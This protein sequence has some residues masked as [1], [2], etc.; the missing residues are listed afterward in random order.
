MPEP[1]IKDLVS[2]SGLAFTGTVESRGMAGTTGLPVDDRTA[3]VQVEQILHAPDQLSVPPGSKIIV[4]L[5]PDQPPLEPGERA[6]FFANGLAY[7][8]QLTVA[9]VGRLPAE[10][11]AA[12]TESLAGVV[13]PVSAVQAV[14]AEIAQDEVSD[15]AAQA[16]AVVRGHVSALTEL[17]HGGPPGEHDPQWWKATLQ[18]DLVARGDIGRQPDGGTVPVDAL[19]ANSLDVQWRDWLKPKA[20]Q[21]G[22]WLLHRPPAERAELASFELK[23]SIDLQPSLQLDLLRERGL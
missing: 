17:P 5:S 23:H 20:G 4:Q 16:D 21:G 14:L 15:H 8:D 9:E 18:V 6:T 12:R 13:A 11:G 19:Y 3:I 22:L 10:A 7:G 2:S 1:T